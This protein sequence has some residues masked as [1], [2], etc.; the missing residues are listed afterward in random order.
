MYESSITGMEMTCLDLLPSSYLT[1][2]ADRKTI[3][4]ILTVLD[5]I[6]DG[7]IQS[8]SYFFKEKQYHFF[9]PHDH[10]DCCDMRAINLLLLETHSLKSDLEFNYF[11]DYLYNRKM[12]VNNKIKYFTKQKEPANPFI[13][14]DFLKNNELIILVNIIDRYIFVSYFLTTFRKKTFGNRKKIAISQIAKQLKIKKKEAKVLGMHYQK[15]ISTLSRAVIIKVSADI[16]AQKKS[17]ESLHL[18]KKQAEA[19]NRAKTEFLENM[20]HDIRTPL[21]GIIGFARLI[22]Q[23]AISER[24]KN[25]ADNLVLATTALLDFQNEIL[26]EIKI[27]TGAEPVTQDV[28]HLK[29]LVEKVLNLVRPKAIVKKITLDFTTE[30]TIP[31]CV[32]GDSKRLF[33]VFL[34]LTTNALKFTHVGKINIHLST[35]K[36]I[37]DQFILCCK[38][39]DTGI[40]IQEDKKDAIFTRFHR[41]SPASEGVYEGTGL[42]LTIVKKYIKDMSGKIGVDSV[43]GH[44]TTFTCH[45]PLSVAAQPVLE[46]ME[47]SNFAEKK[48]AEN[49]RILLVED[50]SMTA[51]VTQIMLQEVGCIVDI[52]SDAKSALENFNKQPYDLIFLDLGLPDCN[53][54]ELA[55]KMR[56]LENDRTHQTPLIALTAH[57]EE[58]NE[59]RCRASGM[60]AIFQKP[61]LKLTAI[62]I[63]NEYLSDDSIHKKIIDLKWGAQ[64]IGKTETDAKDMLDLLLKNNDEDQKNIEQMLN[65]QDWKK[66][67]EA[68]HKL[69]GGLSYCGA[70]CLES[71]CQELQNAL[72]NNDEKNIVCCARRVLFEMTRLKA[73][74]KTFLQSPHSSSLTGVPHSKT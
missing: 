31:E 55:K 40:G 73:F 59:C 62:T 23:D 5:F 27:S 43:V 28:F 30:E 38:I 15:M 6:L 16:S 57:R 68:N 36:T 51:T 47:L 64:R 45:I 67:H 10:S 20:R 4:F 21:T 41:L 14:I 54:F 53:G 32:R 35:T 58:D 7:L 69:I 22:Q 52:A 37:T 12:H 74:S 46:K 49:K 48:L 2:M 66:L 56:H 13:L 63:L 3:L 71:A 42:G 8:Q 18:A 26:D 19:A 17:E 29:K 1:A 65:Q 70:P 9:N 25:Y 50:H 72:K 24:T 34:E 33:R 61:L 60:N 44:G 39:T 11:L